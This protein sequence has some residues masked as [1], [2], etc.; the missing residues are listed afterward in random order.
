MEQ[1]RNKSFSHMGHQFYI[2]PTNAVVTPSGHVMAQL[3]EGDASKWIRQ[4]KLS[5]ELTHLIA[6]FGYTSP[7]ATS[8]KIEK[9]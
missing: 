8:Y 6:L 9:A 3:G 1:P 2:T 7:A 4:A 5:D